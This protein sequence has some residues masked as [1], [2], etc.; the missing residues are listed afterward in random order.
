[1]HFMYGTLLSVYCLV[2]LIFDFML[3]CFYVA[4][5]VW[6]RP[7]FFVFF[8]FVFLVLAVFFLLFCCF[9]AASSINELV[10]FW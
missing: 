1:M 8:T 10:S 3:I 6:F 4:A 7:S 9:M 2:S 5:I